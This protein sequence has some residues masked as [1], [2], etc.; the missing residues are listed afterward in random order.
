M[1]LHCLGQMKNLSMQFRKSN[2]PHDTCDVQQDMVVDY[3]SRQV[4][5]LDVLQMVIDMVQ[6]KGFELSQ[7]SQKLEDSQDSNRQMQ[8]TRNDAQKVRSLYH[9][10]VG[11]HQECSGKPP[12]SFNRQNFRPRNQKDRH[13]YTRDSFH[14]PQ[15]SN[16]EG[17][18]SY[19]PQFHSPR[20]SENQRPTGAVRTPTYGGHQERKPF[21]GRGGPPRNY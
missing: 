8:S 3:F 12:R 10:L 5:I 16:R 9:G 17:P 14:S 18:G 4:D 2:F 1:E 13:P 19:T 7:T 21:R 20:K 15:R 6:Q 11:L